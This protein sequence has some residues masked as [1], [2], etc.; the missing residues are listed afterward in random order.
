MNSIYDRRKNTLIN[1]AYF[2][3]II[4]LFYLFMKYAFWLLSPF[5]F[6]LAVSLILQKPVNAVHEK[7]HI[8]KGVISVVTLILFLLIVVSLLSLIGYKL[9]AEFRGFVEY[10][11]SKFSDLPELISSLRKWALSVA[12]LL[13]GSLEKAATAAIT[14]FADRSMRYAENEVELADMMRLMGF[15]F[16]DLS[17]KL[18]NS[19][20]DISQIASPILSTA[21][22][23]PG[24]LISVIIFFI[25]SFFLTAGY[26]DLVLRIKG[27][28]K[29]ETAAKASTVK[30]V[31]MTSLGKMAKSYAF[32][33]C[34]TFC[35]LA[36]SLNI[37][38]LLGLYEGGYIAVIS[39]CTA[40]LDILPVFGTGTVMIPWALYNLLFAHDTGLG[41][42][43]LVIY[44]L[45]TVLRQI[46]EPKTVGA[47]LGLPP[48][49]TLFGMYMGLETIGFLG[50]FVLPLVMVIVK[51]LNDDG[52][53]HLWGDK[54]ELATE[55]R[56]PEAQA[57]TP[58]G[59]RI[60][61]AAHR[62]A[63]VQNR[64]ESEPPKNSETDEKND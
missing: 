56:I 18:S 10:V 16:S 44:A 9:V 19:S 43:L 12:A 17:E 63:R 40:L 24:M 21:V 54:K 5:I 46:I 4:A 60:S 11:I 51:M 27:A 31:T 25:A 52:V 59:R 2:A 41:I 53:I 45:I 36:V 38:R 47:N 13:P 34:I 3:V 22:K 23:L 42:G 48:I 20:V 64:E 28:V 7:T 50:M 8:R 58:V 33:L 57:V 39:L 30:R 35:E 15:S 49:L 6:A 62:R 55:K 14:D 61:A 1:I 26:D 37:L 29:K 32:I